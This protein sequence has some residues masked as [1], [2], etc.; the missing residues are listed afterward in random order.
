MDVGSSGMP[1]I[2]SD[3]V[4]VVP[5]QI[6]RIISQVDHSLSPEGQ[7]A[8]MRGRLQRGLNRAI[9]QRISQHRSALDLSIPV[10]EEIDVV[11]YL[12][13]SMDLSYQPL[14]K[15]EPSTTS[16]IKKLFKTKDEDKLYGAENRVS[17]GQ[18]ER[19]DIL[20]D[21]YMKAELAEPGALEYLNDSY[22]FQYMVVIS[23]LDILRIPTGLP[24]MEPDLDVR[25]HYDVLD[26]M[27]YPV[28]GGRIDRV[29]NASESSPEALT[30]N[31]FH[32]MADEMI[33]QSEWIGVD[34]ETE[35]PTPAE[36]SSS[37][38]EDY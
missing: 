6:D 20:E 8:N 27:G 36:R 9:V 17:N 33:I 11:D 21:R 3:Q 30:R 13:N 5:V 18:I 26:S 2:P 37:E 35:E 15:K 14:A 16:R 7:V 34:S 4:L 12:Y 23:Q 19:R 25:I 38:D 24:G 32:E 22:P 28:H 29:I 31:L 1:A 10:E